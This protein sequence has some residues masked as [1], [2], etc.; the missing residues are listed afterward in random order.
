MQNN[1]ELKV[2]EFVK[3]HEKLKLK[4]SANPTNCKGRPQ[5]TS[6]SL[7]ETKDGEYLVRLLYLLAPRVH[8]ASTE[9]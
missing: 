6:F 7:P 8:F 1:V 4:H 3:A 2:N 5:R 9:G